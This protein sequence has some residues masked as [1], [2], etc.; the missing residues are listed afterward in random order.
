MTGPLPRRIAPLRLDELDE[1]TREMVASLSA[2]IGAAGG[3]PAHIFGTIAHHPKLLHSWLGL[4]GRLLMGGQLDR[5]HTE[6]V[7]LRTAWNVRSDYEWGQHVRICLDLGIE[8]EVID[9]VPAGPDAPGW[10]P[11][12]VLLVRATDELHADR[13]VGDE[14]WAALEPQL[15]VPQR[16]ELCFLV[17]HY[18]MVAMALRTLGVELDAG[19]EGLPA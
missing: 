5:R 18:E 6:L 15:T 12:E 10:S 13:R 7:I 8:R 4:G 3:E 17:G 19:L 9:R 1:R 11:I 14:T 2:G 16:I